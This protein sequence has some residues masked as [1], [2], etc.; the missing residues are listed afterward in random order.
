MRILFAVKS[1]NHKGGGAE[2]VLS[3]IT[4]GLAKRGHS[5]YLLSFDK[6]LNNPFYPIDPVIIKIGLGSGNVNNKASIIETLGRLVR[7]RKTINSIKP[8]VVVGFM[9][10]MFIPAGLSLLGTGIPVIGSEHIVFAHYQ[11]R[12]LELLLLKLSVF[13]IKK[14]VSVSE[15]AKLTYPT[16]LQKQMEVI[17]N[18]V[19]IEMKQR[20]EVVGEKCQT[21]ILLSIGRMSKQKDHQSLIK[22]FALIVDN[23]PDWKLHIVGDGELREQ[24]GRLIKDLCLENRILLKKTT[25]DISSEYSDAHLFVIPSSYESF[26]LVIIEAFLHGLPVV[27]FADCEGTNELIQHNINGLLVQPVPDRVEGLKQSLQALMA[28]PEDRFRLSQN[29]KVPFGYNTETILTLW[30]TLLYK[31]I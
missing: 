22:A 16:I 7:L 21:K 31:S 12:K 8:D 26:G 19:G 13:F 29:C 4:N 17:Q 2:R 11:S 6:S 1:V 10:S 23:F 14:I 28:S 18:P 5:I 27:G 3:V 15:Q 25:K 30:E 20:A 24:L 9:H